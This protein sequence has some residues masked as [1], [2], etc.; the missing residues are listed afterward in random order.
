M[1]SNVPDG[2]GGILSNL[3][4]LVPI[5]AISLFVLHNPNR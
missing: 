2:V 4:L 1:F 5:L 3:F